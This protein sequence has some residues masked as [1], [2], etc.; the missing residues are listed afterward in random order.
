MRF[1][2]AKHCLANYKDLIAPAIYWNPVSSL[3]ANIGNPIGLAR[4]ARKSRI[5]PFC[6]EYVASTVRPNK[7]SNMLAKPK[8]SDE[9][10]IRPMQINVNR[11]IIN[12]TGYKIVFT[13]I[14]I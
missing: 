11:L 5:N 4:Y 7:L 12:T 14:F 1:E 9:Q 6:H 2:F 3:I 13:T 10:E 8:T